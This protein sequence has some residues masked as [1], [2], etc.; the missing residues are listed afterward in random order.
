MSSFGSDLKGRPWIITVILSDHFGQDFELIRCSEKSNSCRD[1]RTCHH[2]W[3]PLLSA[4]EG[5]KVQRSE[6]LERPRKRASLNNHSG[7]LLPTGLGD[8]PSLRTL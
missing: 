1:P 8:F 7:D 4:S 6:G 5:L 3:V 2:N